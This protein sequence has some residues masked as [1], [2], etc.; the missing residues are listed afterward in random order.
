MI[1]GSVM[2]NIS[3]VVAA[4]SGHKPPPLVDID[5]TVFIQF[6]IF[7]VLLVVLTKL[8]FK[9]YLA[10]RA[11]RQLNIEG[12]RE[13]AERSGTAADEKIARY[14][15]E[16]ARTRR[17]AASVRGEIR[18]QG[19]ARAGELLGEAQAKARGKVAE[20]RAQLEKSTQAAQLALRT[21]ADQMG[22]QIASKLLGREV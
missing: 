5:A 12:A 15:E 14:E 11:E 20:V 8:V 21:R 19:E 17:E 16:V 6:G 1:A 13:E 22:R 9:P 2:N 7:L 4:A 3:L 18:G 10:M